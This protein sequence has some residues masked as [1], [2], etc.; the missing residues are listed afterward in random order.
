MDRK[1]ESPAGE[2]TTTSE[3]FAAS[4]KSKPTRSTPDKPKPSS[5]NKTADLPSRAASA[6]STPAGKAQTKRAT[7]QNGRSTRKKAKTKYD[8]GLSDEGDGSDF[9]FKVI[10][11]DEGSGEDIFGAEYKRGKNGAMDDYQS[12]ED[13][14]EDVK[15]ALKKI[16]KT[17]TLQ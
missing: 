9:E 12:D 13:E 16:R 8:G 15:S 10:K 2:A 5:D 4:G 1:A 6:K 7:A 3:Y 11:D 14:D 17:K